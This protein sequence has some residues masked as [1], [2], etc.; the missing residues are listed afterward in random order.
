MEICNKQ[1]DVR[2]ADLFWS[3]YI[4]STSSQAPHHTHPL[5]H[6]VSPLLFHLLVS[7]S[8]SCQTKQLKNIQSES[9]PKPSNSLVIS[10]GVSNLGHPIQ[11]VSF[12][13]SL[14]KIEST[15][16]G[17][18]G[19]ISYFWIIYS[20]SSNISHWPCLST[21]F[22]PQNT[23]K[24]LDKAISLMGVTVVIIIGLRCTD[25][26]FDPNLTQVLSCSILRLP[27]ARA[28]G[29]CDL[30]IIS[31]KKAGLELPVTWN[32]PLSS[33][34]ASIELWNWQGLFY[35]PLHRTIKTKSKDNVW[36]FWWIKL[37]NKSPL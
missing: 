28:Q 7:N 37:E 23:L 31:R 9:F 25:V 10:W 27:G 14:Q 30:N 22:L 20:P 21:L 18:Q 19:S 6:Y 17:L 26:P 33:T 29:T 32:H 8:A 1:V 34:T 2:Q 3:V 4:P 5:I 13:L 11:H 36:G 35:H 12:Q 16:N 24:T 15:W